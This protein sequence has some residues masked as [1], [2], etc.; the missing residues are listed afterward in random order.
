MQHY[1]VMGLAINI[2]KKKCNYS[3]VSDLASGET[4][5]DSMRWHPGSN[6]K[7]IY[8]CKWDPMTLTNNTLCT[9]VFTFL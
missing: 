2:N 5:K 4:W 7:E 6:Y 9:A 8:D 1:S 3:L